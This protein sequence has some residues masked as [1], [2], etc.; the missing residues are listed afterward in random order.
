MIIARSHAAEDKRR[1]KVVRTDDYTDL[2][3]EI[4]A[5]DEDSGECILMDGGQEKTYSRGPGGI[6]ISGRGRL[7]YRAAP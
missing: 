4:V 2:P 5:A 6:R 1:W 7:V 3:G